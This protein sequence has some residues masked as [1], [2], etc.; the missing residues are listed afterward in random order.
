MA[1]DL[2]ESRQVWILFKSQEVRLGLY[3][4]FAPTTSA[5]VGGVSFNLTWEFFSGYSHLR[6]SSLSNI[7]AQ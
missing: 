1:Y 3:I 6:F 2:Q 7:D 4:N 5:I